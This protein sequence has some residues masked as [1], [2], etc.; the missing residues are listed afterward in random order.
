MQTQPISLT[1][2][3]PSCPLPTP[4]PVCS[5]AGSPTLQQCWHSGEVQPQALLPPF[6]EFFGFERKLWFCFLF[7]FL[8]FQI[9]RDCSFLEL[10]YRFPY[11]VNALVNG[12]PPFLRHLASTIPRLEVGQGQ[13]LGFPFT[14]RWRLFTRKKG[15]K[16]LDTSPVE[17]HCYKPW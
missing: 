6:H 2:N 16:I 1:G 7:T 4:A 12:A 5:S 10:Q 14:W 3:Y 8:T 11:T 13:G 15:M 17:F 9:F